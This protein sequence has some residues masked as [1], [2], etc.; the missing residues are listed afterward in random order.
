MAVIAA[1]EGADAGDEMV[2][3]T[4]QRRKHNHKRKHHHHHR[5]VSEDGNELEQIQS[6]PA[7]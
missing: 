6:E 2:K 3:E 5:A 1:D 7:A 4:K